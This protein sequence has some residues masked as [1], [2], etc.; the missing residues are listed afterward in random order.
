[1]Q[2]VLWSFE[3]NSTNRLPLFVII[4]SKALKIFLQRLASWCQYWRR[5][6]S[7]KQRYFYRTSTR[8]TLL[9]K[10]I[11]VVRTYMITLNKTLLLKS[12]EILNHLWQELYFSF[13]GSIILVDCIF[14]K[15]R[16]FSLV[17][18]EKTC[19]RGVY[20]SFH[21]E[22]KQEYLRWRRYFYLIDK[23]PRWG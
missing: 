18:L 15:R 20:S 21:Y 16:N 17:G 6:L 2:V 22:R 9:L 5:R 8:Y 7:R 10:G 1:M 19:D 13:V 23:H 4:P 11:S 3:M 14:K 12:S